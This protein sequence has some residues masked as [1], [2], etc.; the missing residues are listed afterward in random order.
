MDSHLKYIAC[1][2]DLKKFVEATGATDVVIGL[3]GGVD[4]SLVATMAVDAFGPAHVHGVLLPGPYSTDHASADAL[5]LADNLGIDT[6]TLSIKGAYD[7]FA[8]ELK[9]VCGEAFDGT[10]SQNIQARCRM[11][12]LM[13]LSNAHGW[14]L[15]NTGNKS[16]AAMGYAT[17]YGDMAGAYA[18]IGGLYKTDVYLLC[19][20][21]NEQAAYALGQ[22]HA[23]LYNQT[24][25]GLEPLKKQPI[26]R[27]VINKPASAEL[28]P[29]QTDEDSLGIEYAVLDNILVAHLER[30]KDAEALVEAGFTQEDVDL[31]LKKLAASAFK[32][33]LYAPTSQYEFYA[34]GAEGSAWSY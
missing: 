30:G 28:A 34:E 29:D 12:C 6:M 19:R 23:A 22:A 3:S 17:L 26:P 7:A 18:P 10:T 25:L 5:A 4:S 32:Q 24:M 27:H 31:V 13:A 8:A 1:V 21:R 16:E 9:D 15:L 33:A 14:L 11:I 2:S 20:W